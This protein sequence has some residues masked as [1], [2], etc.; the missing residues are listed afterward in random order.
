MAET[1]D[2]T[3]KIELP[4]PMQLRRFAATVMAAANSGNNLRQWKR[5]VEPTFVW[6]DT[7]YNTENGK[8]EQ[9]ER[10][11]GRFARRVLEVVNNNAEDGIDRVIPDDRWSLLYS[12]LIQDHLYGKEWVGTHKRYSFE[13]DNWGTIKSTCI[14]TEASALHNNQLLPDISMSD[15]GEVELSDSG[16]NDIIRREIVSKE[17]FSALMSNARLY[18]ASLRSNDV[19]A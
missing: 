18:H 17:H 5:T 1:L 9:L 16:S 11:S 14:I 15:D 4:T 19:A 8:V 10:R 13:W 7:R 2:I 6:A 12:E 3:P